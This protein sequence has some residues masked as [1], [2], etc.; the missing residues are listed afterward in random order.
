MNAARTITAHSRSLRGRGPDEADGAGRE[1]EHEQLRRRRARVPPHL[2]L[3]RHGLELRRHEHNVPPLR[4]DRRLL[5]ALVVPKGRDVDVRDQCAAVQV[6]QPRLR[7]AHNKDALCEEK[8]VAPEVPVFP[9][10]APPRLPP[11]EPS[12]L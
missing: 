7:R 3:E 1:R 5:D 8:D 2:H 6:I 4:D 10:R 11:C 12:S 9:V